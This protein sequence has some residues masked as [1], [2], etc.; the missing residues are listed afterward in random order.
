MFRGKFQ[1]QDDFDLAGHRLFNWKWLDDIPHSTAAEGQVISIVGG[2]V[3]WSTVSSGSGTV[4]LAWADI[5]GKPTEF[6]PSSHTHD[7]ATEITGI[8]LVFAPDYHT[9]PLSELEQSGATT[10][11]VPVWNATAT[12]WQA[13]TG[14]SGVTNVSELVGGTFG[15]GTY[16]FPSDV[17]VGGVLSASSISNVLELDNTD[18]FTPT[19]AYHPATKKYVD[20]NIGSAIAHTRMI[21]IE[22]PTATTLFPIFSVP[23]TCTVNRVMHQVDSGS[24]VFN[25]EERASGTPATAGTDV[26]AADKTAVTTLTSETTFANTSLAADSWVYLVA[27][28]LGGTPTKAWIRVVYTEA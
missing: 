17:D 21:Y 12:E 24:L 28:G 16:V 15:A 6:T 8:P 23:A 20:D 10:G 13:G 27:S 19:L 9:H 18:P 2:E 5:T 1:A 11:Q 22:T 14:T 3:A 26:F 25:L 7:Y 4:S